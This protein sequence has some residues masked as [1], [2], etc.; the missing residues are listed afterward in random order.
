MTLSDKQIH[1]RHAAFRVPG[2]HA[3]SNE[4]IE[5]CL[6]ILHLKP[7]ISRPLQELHCL[8]HPFLCELCLGSLSICNVFHAQTADLN[9]ASDYLICNC[10]IDLNRDFMLPCFSKTQILPRQ[11]NISAYLTVA[12]TALQTHTCKSMSLAGCFCSVNAAQP[13]AVAPREA[14]WI[15]DGEIQC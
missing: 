3:T 6:T 9:V 2:M 7:V 12:A 4:W 14:C 8:R 11:V 5:S 10:C 13:P 15:F 1:V